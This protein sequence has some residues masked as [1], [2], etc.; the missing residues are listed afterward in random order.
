MKSQ[1]KAPLVVTRVASVAS[2]SKEETMQGGLLRRCP[3]Q[4][5]VGRGSK[6][7]L[8][9]IVELLRGD[10]CAVQPCK[11]AVTALG[12]SARKRRQVYRWP[13]PWILHP[14]LP[15]S[16]PLVTQSPQPEQRPCC[17][18]A[19]MSLSGALR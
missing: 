5:E 7:D 13:V 11:Q 15:L 4:T 9:E 3:A 17:I 19:E 2:S 1:G 6:A 16:Q 18:G 10:F 8:T 12:G 14:L